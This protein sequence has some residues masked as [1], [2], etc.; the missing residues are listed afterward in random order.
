MPYKRL[1]INLLSVRPEMRCTAINL[2]SQMPQP[3]MIEYARYLFGEVK[4]LVAAI[5]NRRK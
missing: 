3:G 1:D 2:Q 5:T 4:S